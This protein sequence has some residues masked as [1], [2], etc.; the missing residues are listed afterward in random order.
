[1]ET[2]EA[3]HNAARQYCMD[4]IALWRE[5]Y[6]RL[7]AAGLNTISTEADKWTYTPEAY[8]IFPRYQTLEAIQ[9]EIERFRPHEFSSLGE[10]R[11][12]L[13][14][15]GETAQNLF[16]DYVDS[17]A[18]AADLEERQLFSKFV[19]T[20]EEVQL[21]KQQ[22]LPF[23]RVLTDQEHKAM[24]AG[25]ARRW[26]EWYGGSCDR[27]WPQSQV[28][29]LHDAAMSMPNSYTLLRTALTERGEETLFEL[30]EWGD[31]CEIPVE[32]AT[33]KYNGAEGFWTNANFDWLV[34]ASHESSI[35]FGNEWLVSEMRKVL[36]EFDRYIY[37]GWDVT[38]YS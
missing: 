29:T 23:R 4:R 28:V 13:G 19:I 35:T 20:V 2:V 33:F 5:Q 9:T 3:L 24:R 31:G 7:H 8:N 37:K 17:I 18:K 26:G 6:A 21:A 12:L 11:S 10:A 32:S 34:Y 1:M 25:V 27:E 30:R 14:L 15:A 22:A 16:T 36:P 38:K